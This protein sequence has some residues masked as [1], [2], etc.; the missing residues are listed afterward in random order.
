VSG[1]PAESGEIRARDR[2]EQLYEIVELLGSGAMGEVYRARD[3]RIGREVAIK[4]IVPEVAG[5]SEH[6]ERFEQEARAAGALN[7]P[8]ILVIHDI[9]HQNAAPYLVSG[10]LEGQT[11]RD[12]I[13]SG[14]IPLKK[15]LDLAVQITDGL[16]AAHQKGIIH[17]DLKPENIFIN[18][19]GRVKILDFGLAKLTSSTR[20]EP[21]D[22][23][24]GQSSLSPRPGTEM[25]R[26]MGTVG[27]MSPEQVR[28]EIADH[29]SDIFSFGA[30]LYEMLSGK[31]AFGGQ[32]SLDKMEAILNDDPP[33]IL[34][35]N[36]PIPLRWILEHSLAKDT[37]DRYAATTDLNH[38]LRKTRD[39]FADVSSAGLTPVIAPKKRNLFAIFL[40]AF[41]LV[42]TGFV[43]AFFLIP[44]P[45]AIDL[46]SFKTTRLS[47][48]SRY[49][50]Y[51][52]WSPDG[53]SIAYSAVIDGILQVFT[54]RLNSPLATQ[55]TQSSADC[56]VLF[57]S[58]D[59]RRIYYLSSP[60]FDYVPGNL[61]VVGAAGSAPRWLIK[62]IFAAAISGDGKTLYFLRFNEDQSTTLWTSSPP[63][64]PPVQFTKPPFDKSFRGDWI[65]FSPDGS[66][67][68]LLIDNRD[69]AQFWTI[70][71][72]DGKPQKT[73]SDLPTN[74]IWVCQNSLRFI[75]ACEKLRTA[76]RQRLVFDS[77]DPKRGG[78]FLFDVIN[79]ECCLQCFRALE[80]KVALTDENLKVAIA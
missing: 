23:G 22:S 77:S 10:L 5:D 64:A 71:Y 58:M 25:G 28:G 55:L 51:G 78:K 80:M 38:D 65:S 54:R 79:I 6:L 30:I 70:E 8:N 44:T 66:R 60:D 37:S 47:D 16:V 9:G 27:Y 36:L 24:T 12:R 39:H 48:G 52:A 46:S 15:T 67:L 62:N 32:T 4:V 45:Q 18:S 34:N 76:K 68:G 35:L 29:R 57:W 19:D 11:L 53:D 14:P 26:V 31:R 17:R 3:P 7:H 61:F 20:P 43:A 75:L 49:E 2:G 69:N 56:Q 42:L 41:A 21:S 33:A 74:D 1:H 73:V 50:S 59:G 40:I 63:G 72:P 13:N